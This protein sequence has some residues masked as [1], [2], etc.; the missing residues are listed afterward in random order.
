MFEAQ[1]EEQVKYTTKLQT[2][3]KNLREEL[4][5]KEKVLNEMTANMLDHERDNKLLADKLF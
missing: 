2:E 5:V 4:Q 3:T 1:L